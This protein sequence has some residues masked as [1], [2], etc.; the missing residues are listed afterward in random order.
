MFVASYMRNISSESTSVQPQQL[1]PFLRTLAALTQGTSSNK[2]DVGVQ[3]LEV[4]L[5]RPDCRQAVWGIPG[6][7]SG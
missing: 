3:C 2:R 1:L 4:L 7:I 5:A 6:I